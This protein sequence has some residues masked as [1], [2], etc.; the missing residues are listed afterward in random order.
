MSIRMWAFREHCIRHAD[1]CPQNC[2]KCRYADE[3]FED[4]EEEEEEECQST[5]IEQS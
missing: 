5:L 4:E 2:N 1:E 3:L